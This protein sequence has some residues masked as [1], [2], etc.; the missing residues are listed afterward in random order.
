MKK[1]LIGTALVLFLVFLA[2]WSGKDPN[3]STIRDE[4][5][6]NVAD[7]ASIH[8][9]EILD[10]DGQKIVLSRDRN[11]WFVNNQP[12]RQHAI[13]NLLKTMYD[14]RV[15]ALVPKAA[16]D[17]VVK[18]LA[19]HSVR[20]N[21]KDQS[22]K[23]MLVFYIGGVTPDER[24]TFMMR[25]GSEWPVIVNIPGFEGGLR[26][27]YIMSIRD[28]KSRQIIHPIGDIKTIHLEYPTRQEHSLVLTKTD[29]KY[30]VS[31]L[32]NAR[33]GRI[34]VHEYLAEAYLDQINTL[35]AEAILDDSKRPEIDAAT[36]FCR[37]II[38]DP[39]GSVQKV[40][41]YP[42]EWIDYARIG[43]RPEKVERYYTDYNDSVIYLTQHLL[44]QKIFT[45]YEHFVSLKDFGQE[46]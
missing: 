17:N 30:Y 35:Y 13:N 14:Q 22:G 12:A 1:W 45:G 19:S 46:E 6:L 28:W 16:L 24:G 23:S 8:Q 33:A 42:T 39:E 25:E 37:L 7:T 3:E 29:K 38:T 15:S 31:P 43:E 18:D 32:V 5:V 2:W 20:V 44:M 27:R 40:E 4:L 21:V 11:N 10:R 41:F 36:P 34:P 9:I 26:S